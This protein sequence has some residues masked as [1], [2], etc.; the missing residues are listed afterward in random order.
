MNGHPGLASIDISLWFGSEPDRRAAVAEAIGAAARRDGFF[1]VTG[2]GVEAETIARLDAEA[3]AFFALPASEKAGIAMARGGAA[4]RGW[5]PLGG[6]L[7]SGEPDQK[8]GIYFG[9]DLPA[10]DPRVRSGW[11]MHGANLWP[12]RPAGLRGAVEIYMAQT[13]RAATALMEGVSLALGLPAHHFARTYL[14]RPTVLFRVFRYPPAAPSGWGVGEHT[15]YGLLTLMNQDEAGG[16]QVR[17]D[18]GWIDAPPISGTLVCNIGDMLERLSGGQFVSAPHRVINR[19]GRERLSFPIFYDPDFEA[20]MTPAVD[21]SGLEHR[22]RP[23]W[24]SAD[25]N[26]FDGRYGDYLLRKVG[27]VFPALKTSTFPA[28]KTSTG[29]ELQSRR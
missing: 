12:A 27:A 18:Q 15:D 23:R 5:F 21:P 24:D 28:L 4:W 25:P 7:T 10:D 19:S 1:Y 17:T 3:R 2:H 11:P 9:E 20:V 6:E 26:V 13:T 8:E 14:L 29:L 16:L 22:H